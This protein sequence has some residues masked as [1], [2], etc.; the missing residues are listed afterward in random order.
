MAMA[1]AA[2]AKHVAIPN[3]LNREALFGLALLGAGFADVVERENAVG[4][5][6]SHLPRGAGPCEAVRL[7]LA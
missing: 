4:M 2:K 6:M 1:L 3:A 5:E 7:F